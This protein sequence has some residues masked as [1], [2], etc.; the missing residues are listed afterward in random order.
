MTD[1]KLDF[2]KISD[3]VWEQ[4]RKAH[5]AVFDTQYDSIERASAELKEAEIRV[6]YEELR[7]CYYAE[8]EG[9]DDLY[10]AREKELALNYVERYRTI[11]K[12]AKLMRDKRIEE[13][14]GESDVEFL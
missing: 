1:I 6:H 5:D 3:I 13:A 8:I 4:Y 11:A 7:A 14:G 12:Y 2:N 10:W 9:G